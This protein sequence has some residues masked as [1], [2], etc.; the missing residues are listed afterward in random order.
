MDEKEIQKSGKTEIFLNNL[1]GSF[2]KIIF[3]KRWTAA[4]I[5][6]CIGFF[7]SYIF[8]VQIPGS[9]LLQGDQAQYNEYA[10]HLLSGEGYFSHDFFSGLRPPGYP[11]FLFSIYSVFGHS[12][13]AVHFMQC[14]LNAFTCFLCFLLAKRLLKNKE[15]AFLSAI[16]LAFSRGFFE[17]PSN[18]LSGTFFTLVFILSIYF[19]S[20][21][22]EKISKFLLSAFLLGLSALIHPS[23]V[24]IPIFLFLWFI[25]GKR[26][27][28]V[29]TYFLYFLFIACFLITLFPWLNRNYKIYQ[30]IIISTT[31]GQTFAGSNNVRSKG[32]WVSKG[33]KFSD[34]YNE[35]ERDKILYKDGIDYIKTLNSADFFNHY[36]LKI[37]KLFSP[38]RPSYDL[39]F[40]F[41]LPFLIA[42]IILFGF[43][44]QFG[45]RLPLIIVFY[46]LFTTLVFYG[47]PRMRGPYLPYF[48]MFIGVTVFNLFKN[49][50]RSY[51]LFCLLI[52][53]N[54]VL[55][56]SMGWI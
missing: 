23:V 13:F 19:L 28:K 16:I 27:M 36:I 12:F 9:V 33:L 15:I 46:L 47:S 18:I 54:C 25:R 3:S 4:V 17:M 1:H 40:A 43:K 49:Y 50:R 22:E 32:G 53:L 8:T 10:T 56:Y 24:F 7:T 11:L 30:K 45:L 21:P 31:G 39:L 14:I 5:I 44:E 48:S 37:F 26:W 34:N 41:F 51:I 38:F 42:G 52:I 20:D 55:A 2:K 6:F 29:K 35:I